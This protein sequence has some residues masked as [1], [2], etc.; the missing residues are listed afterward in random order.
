MNMI[1]RS[2]FKLLYVFVYS[3]SS[4]SI[5]IKEVKMYE[6]DLKD[7]SDSQYNMNLDKVVEASS[8]KHKEQKKESKID[9]EKLVN[10]LKDIKIKT[11]SEMSQKELVEYKEN[12]LSLLMN[13]H[14]QDEMC[15]DERMD[16]INDIKEID[17]FLVISEEVIQKLKLE[18]TIDEINKKIKS[19][20]K[21][22]EVMAY[23]IS[24]VEKRNNK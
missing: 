9:I 17:T 11:Y 20:Y 19:L 21:D 2:L 10:L 5:N 18:I 3:N 24:E 12:A 7:A 4:K 14:F 23:A 22:M 13:P 1:F 6:Q 8:N 15:R 16:L